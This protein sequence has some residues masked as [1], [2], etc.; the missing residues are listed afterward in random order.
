ME[1]PD[2]IENSENWV[3]PFN[4]VSE[5][6]GVKAAK[7]LTPGA[8]IS[9]CTMAHRKQKHLCQSQEERIKGL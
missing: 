1:V 5:L 9:G 6:R 8:A 7:M 2:K 4:P 3:S